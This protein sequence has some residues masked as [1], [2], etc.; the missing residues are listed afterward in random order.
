MYRYKNKKNLSIPAKQT[1][2]KKMQKSMTFD[3]YEPKEGELCVLFYNK[4]KILQAYNQLPN[5]QVIHIANESMSSRAYTIKLLRM[6]MTPGVADYL[7]AIRGG[8]CAFIEFK[9]SCKH[10]QSPSQIK[11][12]RVMTALGVPYYLVWDV[13]DAINLLLK[14]NNL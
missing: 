13:E 14:L 12:E 5:I 4:V 3:I 10:K 6:G 9:R 8:R 7:V 1:A 11:F 2:K